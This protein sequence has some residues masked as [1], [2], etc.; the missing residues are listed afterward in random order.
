M[1]AGMQQLLQMI[2]WD[3]AKD[4][5]VYDTS[6]MMLGCVRLSLWHG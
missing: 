1:Q 6:C 3:V 5:Q 4:K 2:A